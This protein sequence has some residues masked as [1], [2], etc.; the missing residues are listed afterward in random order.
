MQ[1]EFPNFFNNED[2][3]ALSV[4]IFG[5]LTELKRDSSSSFFPLVSVIM[6]SELK[7]T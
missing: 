4:S 7:L 2:A 1:G 3:V 5:K 6:F